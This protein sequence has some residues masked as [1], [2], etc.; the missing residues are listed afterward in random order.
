MKTESVCSFRDWVEWRRGVQQ[1][2]D[3]AEHF[4]AS[5][6][7]GGPLGHAKEVANGKVKQPA[8]GRPIKSEVVGGFIITSPAGKPSLG[9]KVCDALEFLLVGIHVRIWRWK[10]ARW[11]A[12]L[13]KQQ[14]EKA[15]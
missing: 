10:R 11:Q 5:D 2:A 6:I 14:K 3:H 7:S 12:D 13:A 8:L 4:V 1:H 15:A 9:E